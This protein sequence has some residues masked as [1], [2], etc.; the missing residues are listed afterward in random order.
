M[1]VFYNFSNPESSKITSF[2]FSDL[3]NEIIHSK[4]L[5]MLSFDAVQPI[6]TVFLNINV[7]NLLDSEFSK[8]MGISGKQVWRGIED[9]NLFLQK[10][11]DFKNINS[12]TLKKEISFNL[13]LIL[14]RMS[15]YLNW[16]P[17]FFLLRSKSTQVSIRVYSRVMNL[18]MPY[19]TV[20]WA[21]FS[22]LTCRWDY[23]RFQSI[24]NN[25]TRTCDLQ[26]VQFGWSSQVD[27]I[28]AFNSKSE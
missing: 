4:K 15:I 3:K 10:M 24:K 27:S 16:K 7:L 14:N 17:N 22:K 11:C 1:G 6:N 9:K 25:S 12:N 5:L 21:S 26:F 8:I 28:P 19:C 20:N 2:E 13:L 18:Y 23:W